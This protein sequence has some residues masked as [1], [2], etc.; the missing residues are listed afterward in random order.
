M[1]EASGGPRVAKA[2]PGRSHPLWP[3]WEAISALALPWVGLSWLGPP[4]GLAWRPPWPSQASPKAS[5][6]TPKCRSERPG[7][8]VLAFLVGFAWLDH[9][10]CSYQ[11]IVFPSRRNS[12]FSGLARTTLAPVGA[13][14]PQ[15]HP[16]LTLP[17]PMLVHA[18]PKLVPS[19]P[20]L[21]PSWPQVG[22]CWPRVGPCWL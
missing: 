9:A 13:C 18:G 14:W 5:Q 19:W 15:V 12:D 21:V 6:G 11:K 22:S 4:F 10:W 7:R 20:M 2:L 1:V 3:C 17:R 16:K 8:S